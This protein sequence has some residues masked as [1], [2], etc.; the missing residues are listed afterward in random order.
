[1][2]LTMKFLVLMMEMMVL[3]CTLHISH[4]QLIVGLWTEESKKKH[5]VCKK[6]DDV[7]DG[8]G[9]GDV[10]GVDDCVNH[11][12]DSADNHLTHLSQAAD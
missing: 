5:V 8:D 3:T 7:D 2:A 10:N 6:D 1:M 9:D 12:D 4:K 11:E